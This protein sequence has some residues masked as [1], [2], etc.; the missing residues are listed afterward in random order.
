[1]GTQS[2]PLIDKAQRDSSIDEWL[3]RRRGGGTQHGPSSGGGSV[4][5]ISSAQPPRRAPRRMSGNGG[6]M[7]KGLSP[8]KDLSRSSSLA[9]ISSGLRSNHSAPTLFMANSGRDILKTVT[10]IASDSQS[11]R[12]FAAEMLPRLPG[13]GEAEGKAGD[14]P[15]RTGS[16]PRREIEEINRRLA[17]L[18][19]ERLQIN[20][21]KRMAIA[22]G[23]LAGVGQARPDGGSA[24]A[25]YG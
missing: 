5:S 1:M 23:N 22:A 18:E 8:L 17:M 13:V 19:S 11:S 24:N 16:D 14:T 7:L 21:L 10:R 25:T 15:P 6:V 9:G 4:M 20:D 12:A 2:V 3:A